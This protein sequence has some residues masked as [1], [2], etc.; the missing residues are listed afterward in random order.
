MKKLLVI[1]MLL[2]SV[3]AYG[4]IPYTLTWDANTEPDLAGYRLYYDDKVIDIDDTETSIIVPYT[5]DGYY[6]L[7]A[8]DTEGL[9]SRHTDAV[10]LARY[11][12]NSIKYDFS[13]YGLV[14]Y[15]GENVYQDAV[16]SDTN[17]IVTKFYYNASGMIVQQRIR[18]TSWTDRAVGW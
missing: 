5:T 11:Y 12:Y 17:W 14:L 4:A 3:S 16:D 1:V 13:S 9:E 2:F 8:Y 15:K 18:T 7:T 10:F 6:T